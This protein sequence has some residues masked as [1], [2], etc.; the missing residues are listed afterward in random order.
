M[1]VEAPNVGGLTFDLGLQ[2]YRG[3]V[4]DMEPD[5]NDPKQLVRR[6]VDEVM[7]GRHLDRLDVLCT[8]RLAPKLRVAFQ[9]FL[10]AFPDWRQEIV[11]LVHEDGTVVAHFRCTGTHEGSWRGLS[12]TGRSMRID[13]VYFF[14]VDDGRIGGLWGL[15]DTWS[16]MR[17]LAGDAATLGEL[18]SLT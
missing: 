17:Q 6:L 18:G 2:P 4:A 13:E 1:A 8:N 10:E 9:Q 11:E 5:A 14:R 16:R 15:E 7:N 3:R 12:A